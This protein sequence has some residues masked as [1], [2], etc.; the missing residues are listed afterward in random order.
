MASIVSGRN[1]VIA[2]AI[3]AVAAVV[4]VVVV[5]LLLT[6]GN[7]ASPEPEQEAAATAVP[8]T[9]P[10][11]TPVAPSQPAPT[12]EPAEEESQPRQQAAT[13]TPPPTAVRTEA[14]TPSPI[15][16]Q[17]TIVED[18]PWYSDGVNDLERA[19]S[20]SLEQ[21]ERADPPTSELVTNLPW[22]ADDLTL[23]E[24]LVLP[25]IRDIAAKNPSLSRSVAQLPWLQDEITDDKLVAI[26]S[27]RDIAQEDSAV[28]ERVVETPWVADGVDEEEQFVLDLV[29][30]IAADDPELAQ[31]VLD[32][33]AVSD[34][35]SSAELADFTG[36]Q[37]YYLERIQ[38]EYPGIWEIIR[39]YP[40][41]SD[42]LSRSSA[43]ASSGLLA[44]PLY[45]GELSRL[46]RGAL[47]LVRSIAAIDPA[48]GE[49]IASFSWF[50]D[51]ITLEEYWSLYSLFL[52]TEEDPSLANRLVEL[53]WV[54]D[55][56]EENERKVLRVC[57][58]LSGNDTGQTQLL[59]DQPWFRD[60]ISDE[61]Y[62]L[63]VTLRTGCRWNPFYLELIE[64]GHVRSQTLTRPSGVVN[65]FAVSR[66]PLGPDLDLVFQSL[67]TGIDAIEEFMGPP[68][69]TTDVIV[70][71]EPE[72]RYLRE[73]AGLNYG[74]HIAIRLAPSSGGF[75]GVIY[76]ELAHFYFGYGNAPYWL[77][78]G[79]ANFLESYSLHASEGVSMLSR[80]DLARQWVDRGCV[81][82]GVGSINDL[83]EATVNLTHIE[84]LQSSLWICT[85]PIGESFLLGI[86]NALGHDV[87][88]L[89]LRGVYQRGLSSRLRPS[90]GEIYETFLANT[91]MGDHDE[92]RELYLCLHGRPIP[93][94]TSDGSAVLGLPCPIEIATKPTPVPAP[95]LV[96]GSVAGDR[97]ALVAFY[98]TTGG[99]GWAN[100]DNWLTEQ[101]LEQWYGIE[102]DENGRVA[103]VELK[104]NRLIGQVPREIGRLGALRVLNLAN[105]ITYPCKRR[106]DGGYDCPAESPSA[107]NLTGE[108]PVELGALVNLE[109]MYLGGNRFS[110]TIPA[111][112]GKLG[113]LQSLIIGDNYLTGGIPSELGLLSNLMHLYLGYNQLS[114]GIP[115]SLGNLTDLETLLLWGNELTGPLP[116]EL[117]S[118]TRLDRLS[119]GGNRLDGEIPV[120]LQNLTS[121]RELHLVSNRFSGSI[122]PEIGG[123]TNLEYI[124]LSWNELTGHIPRELANLPALEFLR[125]DGNSIDRVHTCRI[126]KCSE[127]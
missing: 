116:Q 49:R 25:R 63:T 36:S 108:L 127:Q 97:A 62:A 78:E 94:Y 89:S 115:P 86:Y 91:P 119:V 93:G 111:E 48:L 14:P 34:G 79:G 53:P 110:G 95:V 74:T 66:T 76:H 43:H 112:L 68:W 5:V 42:A 56:I 45:A 59:L 101:P 98:N 30:D 16:E 58:L 20:E 4:V 73:V 46:D 61:E 113:N 104:E 41:I 35:V 70:Y 12:N 120:W 64:N 72:L 3:A 123:W 103:N 27:I 6:G 57:W 7:G 106:P 90:E 51:G 52:V 10:E 60:S 11:A 33:P 105:T 26:S 100:N 21:I 88:S 75:R 17:Q 124:D 8:G 92:F 96:S 84:Y 125:L 87:V 47:S 102:T 50:A 23:E 37:N 13:S 85:Y 19:A 126:A 107:N 44:S 80:Y 69:N 67:R 22:L 39:D 121:L 2:L 1:R 83:L 99:P 118:L 9:T 28:A 31:R 24:R 29:R 15:G 32:S 40:W 122:P 65:L 117:A 71:L 55:G 82:Q 77:A 18:L 54:V 114:G 109:E 38:R 81:P